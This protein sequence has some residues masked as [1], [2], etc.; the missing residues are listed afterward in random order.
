MTE[1]AVVTIVGSGPVGSLI[2]LYLARRGFEVTVYERR[3]DIRRTAIS[4]GCSINLALANRGIDALERVGLM[5]LVR[6]RLIPMRGRMIHHETGGTDLLPYGNKPEEVIYSVSRAELNKILMAAAETEGVTI[7]FERRCTGLDLEAGTAALVDETNGGTA[8]AAYDVLIGADGGGSAVRNAVTA[9]GTVVEELLPHGY[10]ELN[11]PPGPGGAFRMEANALHVWPRGGFMLIALPNPDGS[12]TATLFLPHEGAESFAALRRGTDVAE[13][14]NEHFAD[15]VPLI[16][17]LTGS[18]FE[19]P[20][21]TLGTIRCSAWHHRGDAVLIGDAAHAIV[22]FHGQGMNAGFEDCV[23][24]DRCIAGSGGD[25][26]AAFAAY[27]TSRRP[28][29]DAIADM[30][31][32]NYVEMRDTVRDPK[33]LLKKALAFELEE[34]FPDRF[35]PRYSMVMFHLLPYAEAYRRGKLQA[36][37]LDELTES[38]ASLD[39]VDLDRAAQLVEDMV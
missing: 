17:D 36:A 35:I 21:G 20:T 27:E 18:F 2:S 9:A 16:G 38:A 14:F 12:F 3:P 24:L 32:E 13:F 1:G 39:D 31:L 7:R 29:A 30:A 28:D 4:A 19:N 11:I 34:R 8:D 26:A 22:P 33:F 15:T 25:W 37:I 6:P 23:T 5:D 10:K